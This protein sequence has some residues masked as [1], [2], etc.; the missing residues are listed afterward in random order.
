MLDAHGAHMA[1]TY[2]QLRAHSAEL[3]HLKRDVNAICLPE[4]LFNYFDAVA[5]E[6][7]RSPGRKKWLQSNSTPGMRRSAVPCGGDWHTKC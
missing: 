7:N 4:P 3:A 2:T 1:C 6:A 5:R